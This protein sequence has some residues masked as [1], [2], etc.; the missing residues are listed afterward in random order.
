MKSGRYHCIPA[1][2]VEWNGYLFVLCNDKG[3]QLTDVNGKRIF[4]D[5]WKYFDNDAVL[6]SM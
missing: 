6:A 2:A 5:K 1:D 4:A 3:R